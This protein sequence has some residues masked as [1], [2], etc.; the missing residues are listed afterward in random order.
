M[1][2]LENV[3]IVSLISTAMPVAMAFFSLAITRRT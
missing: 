1:M 3:F 2:S